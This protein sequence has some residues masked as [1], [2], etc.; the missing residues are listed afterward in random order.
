MVDKNCTQGTII[1][2]IPSTE[3]IE[4]LT[5]EVYIM[6]VIY[7]FTLLFTSYNTYAYLWI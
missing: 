2:K 1:D 6:I 4:G 5:I 3:Q 7:L